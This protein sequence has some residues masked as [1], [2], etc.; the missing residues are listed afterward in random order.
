M[1]TLILMDRVVSSFPVIVAANRDEFLARP[2]GPPALSQG[3][4][5]PR[6][7]EA[8][9]T[10]MGVNG[11]G[12]FVGLTNR[13]TADI[14]RDRRSRGLLVS[15]ALAA[16]SAA[17]IARELKERGEELPGIYNPF[18][19]LYTDGREAFLTWLEEDGARTRALLP[20][21]HVVCN[22]DEDDPGSDKVTRIRNSVEQIDLE[23]PIER[24]LDD[25][26]TVLGSHPTDNPRENACVHLEEYGTRSSSVIA[27][28]E[29]RSAYRYADGAPCKTEYEDYNRLLDELRSA[30]P[31]RSHQ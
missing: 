4:V 8:G 22:R 7:L 1:C 15:D 3:F 28:G 10:W 20:G 2:A 19:L 11:A 30:S 25:L 21:I 9:G 14:R 31:Q 6:D 26:Q 23:A 24:I 12:V 17:E 5:A 16:G 29:E 13:P 18:H 27:L